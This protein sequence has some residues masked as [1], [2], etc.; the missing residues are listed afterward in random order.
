VAIVGWLALAALGCTDTGSPEP[1]PGQ[2]A[3]PDTIHRGLLVFGHEAR[4]FSPCEGGEEAWVEDRTPGVELEPLYRGLATAPYERIFVEV[5]GDYAAPP[6][7]GFGAKY[8]RMLV[9][10]GLRRAVGEG[11]RCDEP[12]WAFAFRAHGQEP[13]WS[14]TVAESG[15]RISV[16]RPEP[17]L[18]VFPYAA[19]VPDANGGVRYTSVRELPHAEIS[20]ELL[21][22]ACTDSMSGER[23]SHTARIVLDGQEMT[24]CAYAGMPQPGP[25]LEHSMRTIEKKLTG[26]GADGSEICAWFRVDYLETRSGLPEP[27]RRAV[28]AT[29]DAWISAPLA[30]GGEPARPEDLMRSFERDWNEFRL[31]FPD[32]AQ[33]RSIERT[34]SVLAIGGSYVSL[35]L[36]QRA[37]LG[38][39]H[40]TETI[41][42]RTH[43]RQSGER[44]ELSTL[45]R[46]GAH[47]ALT[48]LAEAELR[49]TKGLAP[50]ASLTDAGYWFEGGRFALNEN[51]A[52]TPS[53]LRFRFDPYEIAPYSEGPTTLDL[54]WAAVAPLL[55]DKE[56]GRLFGGAP[57]KD[58]MKQADQ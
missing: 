9:V 2:Q 4:T 36:R 41:A 11:P 38:G 48:E 45:L 14:A 49:R 42:L 10:K 22:A 46:A 13:F 17:S 30:E 12:T 21:P 40:P 32:S 37:D 19:P 43:D 52:L 24:G 57:R 47:E 34:A 23:S 29:I 51:F 8:P 50:D 1:E 44:I 27:A 3:G 26:C 39:A 31:R 55:A 53:G 7:E 6:A 16:A 25:P 28:A 54:S 56:K 18:R 20:I 15:I 35:E 33:R 5:I 58:S